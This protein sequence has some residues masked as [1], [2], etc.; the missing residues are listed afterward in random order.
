[1]K[2]VGRHRGHG[3]WVHARRLGALAGAV[4]FRVP[5]SRQGG[6]AQAQAGRDPP[7]STA[8][9]GPGSQGGEARGC[10]LSFTSEVL[11]VLPYESPLSEPRAMS[12]RMVLSSSRACPRSIPL[13]HPTAQVG[14]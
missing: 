9:C 4:V 7:K 1:M 3:R 8:D 14:P 5:E 6:G 10:L 12:I 2:A 13:L 11:A